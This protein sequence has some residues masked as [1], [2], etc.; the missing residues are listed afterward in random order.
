MMEMFD[1]RVDDFTAGLV[2]QQQAATEAMLNS[3]RG[4]PSVQ[5]PC[6]DEKK[7]KRM[8]IFSGEEFWRDWTFQFK[9]AT[10]TANDA[11]YRLIET[12]EKEEKEIDDVLSLTEGERHL[13][14]A[15]FNILV[16]LVQGEAL[17]MLHM[18]GFSGLEAWRKLSERYS[19]A[20]P[21]KGMQ[22]M[23]AAINPGKAKGLE[24]T[25]THIDRW[26]AKVLALSRDF[27][28][29]LSEK[30]TAAILISMLPPDLQRVP[31]SLRT[32]IF[33]KMIT[34]STPCS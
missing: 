31:T 30:T 14:S 6:V 22:L 16:T 28:E 12:A 21:M 3:E 19:P 18:G 7:Y 29:K 13:S 5:A 32:T 11:A 24:E 10:K 15:T 1:R 8:E 2:Q 26:E 34:V 9:S 23:M 33:V 25:A 17:Q 27:N 20:T 4:Q